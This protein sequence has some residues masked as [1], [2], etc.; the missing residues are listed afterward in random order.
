MT[1]MYSAH[2]SLSE[3][4]FELTPDSRYLFL[5]PQHREA[6]STVA[7]GL[8]SAKPVTV[9]IGE[10]GTGKTSILHA[11]MES[12]RCQHVTPIYI[13]NP[14]L[15]RSEF[16]ETVARRLALGEAATRSKAVMIDELEQVLLRR[17]EQGSIVALI[18]DEAQSLTTEVL[19]EIRLL[20][21]IETPRAKLLPVVMAGQPELGDRMDRHELRQL[22]Q[23]VALRCVLRPLEL[24]DTAAYIATRVRAAGGV[25]AELFTQEAVRL[26]F[27]Y[28]RGIPRTVNIICDNGLLSAMA[29]DRRCVDR[30]IVEEVCADLSLSAPISAPSIETDTPAADVE[31]DA[32]A[33]TSNTAAPLSFRTWLRGRPAARR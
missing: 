21:N 16:V 6:L 33:S 26:I 15:T 8:M 17:R 23:R 12:E 29:Q 31:A 1:G 5:T 19:E 10:A 13:G 30:T 25:P 32:E 24:A 27:E 20:G 22:K 11:A 14:T 3:S 2:Y 4:P 18:V 7:Y 28:S 9:L